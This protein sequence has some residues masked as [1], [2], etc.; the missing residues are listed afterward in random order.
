MP[1]FTIKSD[2][3]SL[4]DQMEAFP[5]PVKAAFCKI[6]EGIEDTSCFDAILLERRAMMEAGGVHVIRR[7]ACCRRL[8]KAVRKV[9][10]VA[11]KVVTVVASVA[12][13]VVDKINSI[14]DFLEVTLVGLFVFAS[15]LLLNISNISNP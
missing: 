1:D 11:I 13:E 7:L 4:L 3:L 8:K 2:D 14:V 10:N 12:L 6:A 9:I 5:D 15:F